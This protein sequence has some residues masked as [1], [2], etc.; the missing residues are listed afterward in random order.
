MKRLFIV[1][2][3]GGK[4]TEPM[5]VWLKAQAEA[6]GFE[7]QVPEMPLS[8]TPNITNWV[9]YLKD[10]VGYID[11]QTY[12]IGHS[13]G[14]QA[15]LRYLQDPDGVELGGAVLIAPWMTLTGLETDSERDIA[16]PWIENPIDFAKVRKTVKSPEKFVT[17]F[18]DNDADVPFAENQA[19]FEKNLKP[20]VIVEHGKGHFTEEDGVVSLQSAFDELVK[21]SS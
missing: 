1:H 10:I 15:I 3:W 20:A 14:T 18:S 6:A 2:G 7:V 17:I 12:F 11:E 13:I 21:L 4:P 19:L 16:R 9:N 5:L 8:D